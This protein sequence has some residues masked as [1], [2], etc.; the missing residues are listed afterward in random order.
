MDSKSILRDF[1]TLLLAVLVGSGVAAIS[2]SDDPGDSAYDSSAPSSGFVQGASSPL[3]AAH[4]AARS[5]T[6][7]IACASAWE[8]LKDERLKRD[9]R[10][11]AQLVLLEEWIRHDPAAALVAFSSELRPGTGFSFSRIDFDPLP[12]MTANPDVVEHLLKSGCLGVHSHLF[13]VMWFRHL[14]ELDPVGTFD[15]LGELPGGRRNEILEA[16]ARELPSIS[17]DPV[18]WQEGMERISSVISRPVKEAETQAIVE[19][20]GS[21]TSLGDLNAAYVATV[22]PDLRNLFVRAARESARGDDPFADEQEIPD[23]FHSLSEPFRSAVIGKLKKLSTAEGP[24]PP[25]SEE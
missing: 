7:A 1:A 17:E 11:N 8:S 19:G 18:I 4:P 21:G 14:A 9:Q 23:E 24:L 12:T 15:R 5:S 6:E 22:D 13:K 25:S 20:L 3:V 16:V 10:V 2:S